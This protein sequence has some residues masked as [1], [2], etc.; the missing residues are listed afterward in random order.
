ME[1]DGER[2]LCQRLRFNQEKKE[3]R[4]KLESLALRVRITNRA[5]RTQERG[6]VTR[7]ARTHHQYHRHPRERD[8]AIRVCDAI[9]TPRGRK[10]RER[11]AKSKNEMIIGYG[12]TIF[13]HEIKKQIS[14]PTIFPYKNGKRSLAPVVAALV[15]SVR[16]LLGG[17][18]SRTRGERARFRVRGKG[19]HILTI[20]FCV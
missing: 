18:D 8:D 4:E 15:V 16:L 1:K 13:P 5:R 11:S 20:L 17:E 10:E 3:R 2:F 7:R 9:V 6:G 19:R 12:R 14:Q